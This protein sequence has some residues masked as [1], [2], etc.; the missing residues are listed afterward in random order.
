MM[1]AV[2][3]HLCVHNSLMACLVLTVRLLPRIRKRPVDLIGRARQCAPVVVRLISCTRLFLFCQFHCQRHRAHALL[4]QTDNYTTSVVGNVSMAWIRKASLTP[5]HMHTDIRSSKN[6]N[7][8]W[9]AYCDV[10]T[11]CCQH[12]N[13]THTHT[14]T[15]IDALPYG[16]KHTRTR[17]HTHAHHPPHAHQQ[18]VKEDPTRP[19][20]AYIAPKVT[21]GCVFVCVHACARKQLHAHD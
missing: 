5:V 10:H 6:K 17:K 1:V 15:D 18:A 2:F 7:W 13:Q 20:F 3:V 14:H 4:E 9:H 11:G 12:A 16:C 19:F 21:T 8:R